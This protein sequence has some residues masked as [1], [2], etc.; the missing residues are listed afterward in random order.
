[1][2]NTVCHSGVASYRRASQNELAALPAEQRSV[3]VASDDFALKI[4]VI[5][6]SRLSS[7]SLCV[8]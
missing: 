5:I 8:C 6:R 4:L 2:A 1:M 7:V 3:Q